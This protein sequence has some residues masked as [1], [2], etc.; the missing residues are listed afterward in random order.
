MLGTYDSSTKRH[1]PSEDKTKFTM[2]NV[3]IKTK[4]MPSEIYF[5][6]IQCTTEKRTSP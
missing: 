1:Y 2:S 6:K 4:G 3:F 5:Q